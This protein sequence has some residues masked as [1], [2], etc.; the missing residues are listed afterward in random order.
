MVRVGIDER[1][2]RVHRREHAMFLTEVASRAGNLNPDDPT[3][4][5]SLHEFLMHWLAFHILV[6][7]QNMARQVT[8][9]EGGATPSEAFEAQQREAD[10]STEPLLVAM[11]GLFEQVSIQ[12]AELRELTRSLEQR[13][14]DRTRALSEANR[15]LEVIALR[16]SLTQLPNRRHGMR[17]LAERWAES[18]ETGRPL[19]CLMIDA[20]HFKQINDT[21]GHDAG[22]RVLVELSRTLSGALR[23]DDLLCRLGGDE[24]LVVCPATDL[25][26]ATHLAKEAGRNCVRVAP[27]G[28]APPVVR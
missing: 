17:W 6:Q 16:D 26:G 11:S 8:T 13:V 4:A 24:F 21:Q 25:D 20:D 12:N 22:D 10:R 27:A 14:A 23:T 19:A 1:H 28:A 5:R 7:D 9:I 18:S 15:R 2:L 3:L